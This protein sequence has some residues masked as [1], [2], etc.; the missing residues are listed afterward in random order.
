MLQTNNYFISSLR[1][2]SSTKEMDAALELVEFFS[3]I[4]GFRIAFEQAITR[5]NENISAKSELSQLELSKILAIDTSDVV[6]R[7]YKANFPDTATRKRKRNVVVSKSHE[8][9]QMNIEFLQVDEIEELGTVWTMSPPCQ[10]F[11]TTHKAKQLGRKDCRNRALQN[12]IFK[13]YSIKKKPKIIFFENVKGFA[14]TDVHEEFIKCLK[15]NNYSCR[16]YLLSPLQFG[17]PMNRTRFYIC[18][19]Q[20]DLVTES[21]HA[22]KVLTCIPN[23]D[24]NIKNT[25]SSSVLNKNSLDK[26]NINGL[27]ELCSGP[28][29]AF[30]LKYFIE[31]KVKD[32]FFL[33]KETLDKKYAPGLSMV[34]AYDRITFCFTSSYGQRLHKSSGSFLHVDKGYGK[35]V[36][37]SEENIVAANSGKVRY[38]TPKELLRLFGYPSWYKLDNIKDISLKQQ[39]RVIGQSISITVVEKIIYHTLCEVFMNAKNQNL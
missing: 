21:F 34:G 16:Q 11:T 15:E 17:I 13:I 2:S 28:D 1:D 25:Q 29:T 7:C 36:D 27:H 33:S 8:L 30:P 4:G 31:D 26:A 9:L 19:I 24:I 23:H 39:W 12:I 38:F 6:N 20:K 32:H 22:E 18:A 10:P 14:G 37:K 5:F 3:G 35:E